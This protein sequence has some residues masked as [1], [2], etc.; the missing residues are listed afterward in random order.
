[1]KKIILLFIVA[2]FSLTSVFGADMTT[3]FE[4][5][6]GKKDFIVADVPADKAAANGFEKLTVVLNSAPTSKDINAMKQLVATIDATQKL[7]S[8]SQQGVNVTVFLAPASTD[9]T[10]F[11]V[12]FVLDKNDNEDKSLVVL[13]GTCTPAG[14]QTAIQNMSLED[15]IGG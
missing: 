14:M 5:I 3:V 9:G 13:Y 15:L 10:L 8:V 7:T 1:M 6:L 11:K 2:F 4:Q 12:M